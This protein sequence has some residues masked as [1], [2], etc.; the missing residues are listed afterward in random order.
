MRRGAPPAARHNA[1]VKPHQMELQIRDIVI[2]QLEM[3]GHFD[4][5]PITRFRDLVA[6]SIESDLDHLRK[7]FLK[8][9]AKPEA[10]KIEQQMVA[11]FMDDELYFLEETQEMAD[12]LVV[13]ALY[14][15][16]EIL[17]KRLCKIGVQGVNSRD[18]FRFEKVAECLKNVGI[19]IRTIPEY[20]IVDELRCLNNAIKHEGKAGPELAKFGWTI[21]DP[22]EGISDS[23]DRFENGC[24]IFT[25][26]LREALVSAQV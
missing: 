9:R 17:V 12:C 15:R 6:Q 22:I 26:G 20:E 5:D 11:S 13:S 3:I 14:S 4:H 18:L 16:L 7:E 25:D 8:A 2:M 24:R 1:D 10:S 23:Y 21:G 19:D